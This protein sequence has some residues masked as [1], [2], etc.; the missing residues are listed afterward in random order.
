M[1]SQYDTYGNLKIKSVMMDAPSGLVFHDSNDDSKTVTLKVSGAI[2]AGNTDVALPVSGNLLTSTS[3]LPAANITGIHTLGSATLVDADTF[4]FA[5][6]NDSHN[7]KRALASA[8]KTFINAGASEFPSATDLQMMISD[9]ADNYSSA[10]IGGD[11]TVANAT[12]SMTIANNA[13]NAVKLA[14]GAVEEAKIASGAVT[15]DKLGA[16]AVQ[17]AKIA[18]GAVTADK[19]GA[20]AVTSA[21][22]G[23]GAVDQTALASNAVQEAK[24]ADN[25]VSNAK[26]AGNIAQAKLADGFTT[27]G[28]WAN[29]KL[30]SVDANGDASGGRHLSLSGSVDVG[31]A[32]AFYVGDKTSDGSWR[33]RVNGADIVWEKRETGT[34]NQKGS[35]TA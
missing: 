13:V 16:N 30:C 35:F 21:K 8:L 31:G 4:M 27:A 1:S 2:G 32:E 5:D 15:A 22:L 19:L 26:L 14:T 18:S 34:W 28:T 20:G 7:P 29:S 17:E 24:I 25:A 23:A 10:T 11:L 3:D 9:G 33:M 6:A 12:G